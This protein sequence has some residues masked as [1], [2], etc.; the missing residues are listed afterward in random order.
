[1]RKL[2]K[3]R[4]SKIAALALALFA[5][6]SLVPNALAA[7]D[8]TFQKTLLPLTTNTY[9][10]GSSTAVWKGGYFNNLVI[11]ALGSTGSPCLYVVNASGQIAT[12][13]CGG[14]ISINGV[15]STSFTFST[16]TA[17]NTWNIT[18]PSGSIIR[19]TLPSNIG[20][21]TNDSGYITLAS[22]SGTSP[23]TY[24]S[25]TGA[26]GINIANGSQSGA[27]SN[28]DWTTFNNKE[29]AITAGTS[30]QY[31][32]G[33]K[34]FQTLNQAAVAGLTTG[35]SPTFTGETLSGLAGG[36]TL[37]L[38]VSN[39]GVIGTAAADCGTGAGGITSLNGSA[40]TTQTFA[41]GTGISVST[42]NGVHT[43]T[44]V[45]VTSLAGTANQ[46]TASAATGTITLSTPQDIATASTPQFARLGLGAAA[47][48]NN[49]LNLNQGTITTNKNAIY[50]TSTW[51]G[52][53]VAFDLLSFKITDTASAATSTLQSFQVGGANKWVI[54]KDGTVTTG[55]W[56][57]T[58]I[59][60][61]VGGTGA[62]T[63]TQGDLLYGASN[64]WSKLAKNATATRYLSNTGASNDPAW[65]QI[66]LSNGI[67]GD[68]PFANL[69]QGA[70]LT[71]LANATNGT[72]DFAALAAAS[73]DQVLRRSGTALAFGAV[74]LAGAN[75]ITGDLPLANLTQGSARSVFGVTGNS[76]ADVASI[77]GTA[78]QV[79]RV[80]GAGTALAFGQVDLSKAAAV[81]STLVVGNGGS[82]AAT[83]TA[84]G[85]LLGN[86][87]SAFN[88]TG[89]GTSGQVLTS[90]GSSADPTFQ[91]AALAPNILIATT[92][93]TWTKPSGASMVRVVCI[94]AGGGGGSGRRNLA[95]GTVGG[96]SGGGGGA[97]S[98]LTFQ[99]SFLSATTTVTVGSGGTGGAAKSADGNGN[100]GNDGGGSS[101]GAYLVCGGGGAGTG[102]AAATVAGGGGGGSNTSAVLGAAGAPG[103]AANTSGIG[104]QGV[105][106]STAADG[107]N[108]EWGGGSGGPG[109][110]GTGIL[111][112]GSS[113]FGC[114]GGG[115]GGSDNATTG[116]A[117]GTTQ[118]YSAGGGGAGGASAGANGT[119]GSTNAIVGKAYCGSGGGAGSG[120]SGSG[121]S[122]T[123]GVGGAP[124]GGGGGGGAKTGTAANGGAGGTG[125]RGEVRIYTW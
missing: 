125:G 104:G 4:F 37:C 118:S 47:S 35:S 58:A 83:F 85:V 86:T 56:G 28:T 120:Q 39:T 80:N 72:A 59:G 17:S 116:G 106:Q 110:T 57:G 55:I 65:A 105:S 40:S 119:D 77:Q 38:H 10:V 91:A 63:V 113:I 14:A 90:N 81:T 64:A 100:N 69:T 122:G 29:G 46:I 6:A 48:A 111:K 61:T 114:P 52:S 78:D 49:L 53:G 101:F 82:G 2:F 34:T 60:A 70:A 23:I 68:L 67:T 98:E 97:V 44:N 89:A 12:T 8:T 32:R 84:H 5:V 96:G 123:G 108:S 41:N 19:F 71:V 24:N 99:A 102:G 103:A 13:T 73:D 109:I 27:I 11:P 18:N 88:V 7:P 26:I 66:D 42:L 94:G 1:M 22:I 112:G 121:T 76:T 62:T 87:T 51:N 21:F 20:F 115:G 92:T 79:L 30:A 74:N 45:G 43:I 93:Q 75:A 50:S 36:G 54:Q 9:D 16:S 15:G 107:T 31:W 25:G 117:G 95:G 33:D 3:K 124:G